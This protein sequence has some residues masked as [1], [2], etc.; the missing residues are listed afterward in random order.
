MSR[1]SFCYSVPVT[2]PL[3]DRRV[4]LAGVT[5]GLL[6]GATFRAL[7]G[8][9]HLQTAF[10][11]M[12]LAFI[13]VVPFALGYLTVAIGER[14]RPWGWLAR[15]VAP[16]LTAVVTLTAGLLLAWEGLIC[17]VLWLPLTAILAIL[18]GL[19]AA[20][21]GLLTRRRQTRTVAMCVVAGL[22]LLVAPV[23]KLRH[24]PQE[25][26]PVHTAMDIAADPAV[27]WRAISR[28]RAFEPAEHGFA[29]THAIGFP[30]PV[31][32]TLEGEGVG[33]VRHA[34]FEGGVVFVER[35]TAWEPGQRLAF[36]VHADPNAIPMRTLDQHVT[37]GGEYFDVLEGEYRLEALGPGLVRL[38]LTSRHRL[39]TRFNAYARLWT[40]FVMADIQRYI[41]ARLKMRAEAGRP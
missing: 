21:V 18:G 33:A 27:I 31:E 1:E 14:E 6:Y 3:P 30:R 11:V 41:L 35:V 19:T 16:M 13:F 28:V 37:V 20:I 15:I 24:L 32:A 2:Q 7:F 10:G 12:T 26:R 5:A 40:D 29:W 38:H 17:V 4:I 25:V 22:P 9:G 8:A 34:S 36:T 23:E 39:S